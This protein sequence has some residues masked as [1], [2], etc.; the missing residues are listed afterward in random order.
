MNTLVRCACV[1]LLLVIINDSDA[2]DGFTD[3]LTRVTEADSSRTRIAN[4]HDLATTLPG[5]HSWNTPDARMFKNTRESL[6]G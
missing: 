2:S 1:E 5:G 6:Q 4:F 3:L